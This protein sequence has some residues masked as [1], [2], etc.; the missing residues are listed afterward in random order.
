M[1]GDHSEFLEYL[2]LACGEPRLVT[3]SELLAS[4]RA[5]ALPIS[6]RQLTFYV[7][8][9]LLPRSVRV[10]SRAGAY[11]KSVVNLLT[12]IL[13]FRERGVPV[14]AIKELLPVWKFLVRSRNEGR[15]ELAEFEYIIRQKVH[16]FEANI[17]VP[18]LLVDVIMDFCSDCRRKLCIVT[19]EGREL[20]LSDPKAT[21]GF[22]AARRRQDESGESTLHWW[23]YRRVTLAVPPEDYG[24]D[25]TTIILGLRPNEKLPNCDAGQPA[26]SKEAPGSNEE[27]ITVEADDLVS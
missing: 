8:E 11:P 18:E 12:W 23:G 14:E 10:G 1:P 27:P 4:V 5:R 24:S 16:T 7:T 13:R 15:L 2:Q 19:K 25:P 9:G 20:Q 17:A 3:K 22:A 21:V 26:L 6:D